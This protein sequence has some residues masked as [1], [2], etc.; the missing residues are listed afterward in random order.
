MGEQ[1]QLQDILVLPF[2][3]LPI[4]ATGESAGLHFPEAI[5]VQASPQEEQMTPICNCLINVVNPERGEKK[6]IPTF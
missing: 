3:S 2:C 4:T 1:A 5:L 6:T